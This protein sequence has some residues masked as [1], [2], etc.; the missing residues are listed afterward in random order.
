MPKRNGAVASAVPVHLRVEPAHFDWRWRE[1]PVLALLAGEALT[2][3]PPARLRRVQVES[4]GTTINFRPAAIIKR[5]IAVSAAHRCRYGAA[6]AYASSTSTRKTA[7]RVSMDD[8]CFVRSCNALSPL[9]LPIERAESNS[10]C[11]AGRRLI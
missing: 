8:R 1:R 6:R 11:R 2:R 4:I 10:H 5:D 7:A 9:K 3:D